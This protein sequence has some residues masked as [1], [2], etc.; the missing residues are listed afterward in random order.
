MTVIPEPRGHRIGSCNRIQ[1]ELCLPRLGAAPKRLA[2]LAVQGSDWLSEDNP[3]PSIQVPPPGDTERP[4][5][6]HTALS[7]ALATSHG[8]KYKSV[9][10]VRMVGRDWL[11]M[12]C[13]Q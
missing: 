6:L 1:E 13:A 12:E 10:L 8:V 3:S 2:H 7:V 4:L 9:W 11:V 5:N